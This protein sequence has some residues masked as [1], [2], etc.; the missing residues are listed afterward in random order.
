[1]SS[2]Q[3]EAVVQE[4]RELLEQARHNSDEAPEMRQSR[5]LGVFL[6][7]A[8]IR[9]FEEQLWRVPVSCSVFAQRGDLLAGLCAAQR[10]VQTE[11]G[12][13]LPSVPDSWFP[14]APAA[15][16]TLRHHLL[17]TLTP[18]VWQ[19]E[20][21]LG[22]LYQAW[23]TA[24]PT[25]KHHSTFYTPTPV[26]DYIVAHA[27]ERLDNRGARLTVLD[28]ACGAGM[29]ALRAFDR[30]YQSALRL[31]QADN[32]AWRT[33][34]PQRILG[35][36]LFLVDNNPWACRLAW[37]N[38]YL[39]AK[40][41]EPQ[42]RIETIR[43]FEADALQ[44]WE[45]GTQR[46]LRNVFTTRYDL[47]VG[48]P[49]YR[50]I[51]QLHTPRDLVQVYKMYQS[52]AFKMNTFALFIERGVTLL[53]PDGVL[54]MV[55]PN[56]FLTQVYFEPLRQYLLQTCRILRILDTKRVF[57]S[58]FVENSILL[59]QRETD[60]LKR[61]EHAVECL[62]PAHSATRSRRADVQDA[63]DALHTIGWITQRHFEETPLHIF[64][65]HL[66]EPTF[67]L[68]EK[69]TRG[70]PKLGDICESHDGVNPGNAR[71]KLIVPERVDDTCRKVLNG[72]DIG[73]YWLRWG[74]LYV[75][76]DRRLLVKGDNVRWGHRRA[77]D[78]PKI[79]TRQ[80]ADRLIGAYD[81]GEYYVTNSIHTTILREGVAGWALKYLLGLLNSKLL[82]WYYRKLFPET[83]Q[84]FS[85]VKLVNLRQLPSMPAE[86][87]EQQAVIGLVE[88]LLDVCESLRPGQASTDEAAIQQTRLRLDALDTELDQ[89]IYRLYDLTAEESQRV[90]HEMRSQEF[91]TN[92]KKSLDKK[93]PPSL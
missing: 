82:S 27:L 72:K 74:G 41:L 15:L 87:V 58:A 18:E 16:H 77:L 22:W 46:E 6:A 68:V 54:G 10:R 67:A 52:A 24:T 60:A 31:P 26:A 7:C 11:I 32:S 30:L 63:L 38:L 90:E 9:C 79:L 14:P 13:V 40:R 25:Q 5:A 3:L 44:R 39:K 20:H 48:N 47:V 73:R 65:M 43:I 4:C 53:K 8:A 57:D 62:T 71:P 29:F 56:T 88:A 64:R 81:P 75:R 12:D 34:I 35:R 76:Y 23:N 50:V 69:I 33:T 83:G 86:A 51:N 45:T 2:K 66:D 55:V 70:K 59:L 1:M 61:R 80:T 89:R 49:P 92:R 19:D 36:Q 84:V 37:I 91:R 42:G 93:S 28:P 85:Q 17:E 21:I 78:G